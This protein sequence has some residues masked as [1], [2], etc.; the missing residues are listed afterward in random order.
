MNYRLATIFPEKVE[1]LDVTEIIDLNVRDPIS[2]ISVINKTIAGASMAPL[3]H[4]ASAVT[5]IEVVD[6]SDVLFSLSGLE[7]QALDWYH[8]KKEPSN[9][10]F[11][12]NANWSEQVYFLN[13]GRH[14]YDPL[15]ALDP[16]KFTNL[17][18][19][20]SLDLDAWDTNAGNSRL[21]VVADLFDAKEVAPTGFLMHKQIKDYALG[22]GT[23]E[24][25]DLPTDYP[26]R[27]LLL[28][29]AKAG[30]GTEHCFGTVK[31]SE[32]NDKK[33]PINH[34]IA[35]I[36]RTIVSEAPPYREWIITVG[37]GAG[38]DIYNTPAYWPAFSG[39][40]WQGSQVTT[41]VTV[42]AGDGGKATVYGGTDGV[43]VQVLCEGWCPHGV[44][45]IP[46]GLQDDLDD[47][48]DVT[49]LGSL[50]LDLTAG[51]GML[52]SDS[53]QVFLQQMRTYA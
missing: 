35:H 8:R 13:F 42:N 31:L 24:Y 11:A 29:I 52:V 6:G 10:Y 25:T 30:V 26:M 9:I 17:Q 22:D 44:I 14:L 4:P 37:E 40:N 12:V 47:W 41:A 19:K 38:V 36:L 23:H 21:S 39:T 27:K 43:N 51:G 34:S 1:T 20:V 15:L 45:E 50:V 28:R 5:K 48:Y 33:I 49:Q 32:D 16:T 46:F 18:L 53:C 3:G 2:R 7:A